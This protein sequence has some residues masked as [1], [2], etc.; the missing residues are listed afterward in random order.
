MHADAGDKVPD[1]FSGC[2]EEDTKMTNTQFFFAVIL[3]VLDALHEL[4]LLILTGA[5]AVDLL[6]HIKAKEKELR[7][8]LAN[9]P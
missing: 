7:A 4:E 2:P 6:K 3:A 5:T 1:V 8:R 9:N